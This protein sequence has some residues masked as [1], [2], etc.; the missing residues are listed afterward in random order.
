MPQDGIIEDLMCPE[1]TIDYSA[2]TSPDGDAQREETFFTPYYYSVVTFT[3]LGFGDIKPK[4]L[5]AEILLTIEVVL[6]Y[7]FLGG[8]VSILATKL[9]RRS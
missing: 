6:G 3:T 8:L 7:F 9:A 1:F 5:S 2:E 4:N